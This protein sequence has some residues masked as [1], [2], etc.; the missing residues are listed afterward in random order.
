MSEGLRHGYGRLT[1]A[2]SPVVYEGQWQHSKRCGRGVLYYNADRTAYYDGK[3]FRQLSGSTG[4]HPTF[5]LQTAD[6]PCSA[7]CPEL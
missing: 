3:L 4:T 6:V 1:M 2:N 5:N 7:H